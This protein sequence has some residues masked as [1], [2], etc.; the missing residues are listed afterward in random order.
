VKS[1]A[2][3]LRKEGGG[4]PLIEALRRDYRQA[5]LT[6]RER[7]MLDYAWR[8][9]VAPAAVQEDDVARLRAEGFDDRAIV[10]IN[11]L[12]ATMSFMNRVADGLGV[13]REGGSRAT[14]PSSS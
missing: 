2:E 8:L 6:E 9:T 4:D 13:E 10:Q 5:D 11:L 1:H 7:A 12:A 14:P 3:A